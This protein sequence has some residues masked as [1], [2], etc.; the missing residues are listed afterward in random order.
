MP[1]DVDPTATADRATWHIS[2]RVARKDSE[3]L[4]IVTAINSSIKVMLDGGRTSYFRHGE[5]ANIQLPPP[6]HSSSASSR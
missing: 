4:G 6:N 5:T 3:E 2:Q 1:H